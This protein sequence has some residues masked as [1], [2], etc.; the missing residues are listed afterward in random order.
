MAS[1]LK[2][3]DKR[4][5]ERVLIR[6]PVHIKGVAEDGSAVLEPAEAVVVSRYGALLRTSTRL[7]KGSPLAVTNGFSKET[8]EFHVVWASEKQTDGGWDTGIEAK[9]PREDFWG[10]R[11]PPRDPKA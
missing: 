1:E 8:E 4:R 2:L 10:I 11:F 9:N 6:V 5:G 3:R 7:K